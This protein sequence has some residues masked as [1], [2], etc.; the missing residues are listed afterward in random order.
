MGDS[1]TTG[2]YIITDSSFNGNQGYQGAAIHVQGPLNSLNIESS[3]FTSN[4]ANTNGGAIYFA[5]SSVRLVPKIENSLFKKNQAQNGGAI[6]VGNQPLYIQSS[7]FDSNSAKDGGA[8]ASFSESIIFN[9]FFH[10]LN[11]K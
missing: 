8:I 3:D 11:N 7:T 9:Y 1:S 4:I 2:N 6:F 10:I 5:N